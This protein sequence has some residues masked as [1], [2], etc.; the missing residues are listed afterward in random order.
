MT[1]TVVSWG[2]AYQDS[3]RKAFFEPF[4]KETGSKIIEEEF[5]GEIAKIRAMVETNNITWDIVEND[6]MTT[7]AACAELGQARLEAR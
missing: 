3:V 5:N 7:M 4:M 6:S 2:G 1:V